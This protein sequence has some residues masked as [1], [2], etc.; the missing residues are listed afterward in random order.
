MY[1][2]VSACAQYSEFIL[3]CTKDFNFSHHQMSI[4]GKIY[5]ITLLP[6]NRERGERKRRRA[7]ECE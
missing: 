6:V 7:Q 2:L 5:F 3:D 1:V 4:K